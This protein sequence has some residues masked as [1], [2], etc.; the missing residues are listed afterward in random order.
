MYFDQ[1]NNNVFLGYVQPRWKLV[2]LSIDLNG[3][4][5]AEFIDKY[6]S[7]LSQF[8]ISVARGVTCVIIIF[9][10]MQLM[11]FFIH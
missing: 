3:H 2:D 1:N 9:R 4:F 10:L 5:D 11:Q 8:V 6:C 7:D